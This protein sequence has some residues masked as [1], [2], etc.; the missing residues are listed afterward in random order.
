M[1]VNS[2]EVVNV[3]LTTMRNVHRQGM[4]FLYPIIVDIITLAIG[5][6]LVGFIG[7]SKFSIKLILEMGF[8]SVADISSIEVFANQMIILNKVDVVHTYIVAIVILLILVRAYF[9]GGYIRFLSNIVKGQEYSFKQLM[10]DGKKYWFQF[11][12]LE[13]VVFFLKIGIAG[14]LLMFFPG[15]GAAF[16]LLFLIALRIIF[17]YLEYTIVERNVSIPRAM[18][19]S[20]KYYFRSFFPTTWTIIL[21]YFLVAGLSF[22][23]H[24]QWSYLMVFSMIV[25]YSYLMTLVQAIF[26]HIFSKLDK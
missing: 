26:M 16:A 4:I 9:Q 11:I 15:A 25:I 23:L 13:L 3:L 19:L 20:R 7:E 22:L 6:Y 24:D 1:K 2:K 5:L 10:L 18:K 17:V 12:I 21:M 8:P 14:F